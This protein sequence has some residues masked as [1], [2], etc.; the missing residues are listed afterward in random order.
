[1]GI[2][3]PLPESAKWFSALTTHLPMVFYILDAEGT[4]IMSEGL[5]LRKLGLKPG[6]VVGLSVFEVYK[7]YPDIV[8]CIRKALCGEY[9]VFDHAVG[10]FHVENH[11][12]P[13]FDETGKL[14]GLICAA[15][16]IDKR[17]Q[18]E[19]SLDRERTLT[20][21]I[22]NSVPGILYLYDAE[23]HL[24]YW[25]KSHEELTG[26]S[27]EELGRMTLPDWYRGDEAELA[28]IMEKVRIA[29]GG[30][31]T[32]ADANLLLKSGERLPMHLTA[33][34]LNID[35]KPHIT[36]I[37]IDNSE[38]K[39]AQ[40]R[41]L[42]MNRNL[43]AI[44][45]ERTRELT[46]AVQELKTTNEKM[47]SMQRFMIQS[48]KMAA[49]GNLVAGV[50]HEINTPIGI[51]V[52]GTSHLLDKTQ[53]LRSKHAQDG[54]EPAELDAYLEYV[55][56]AADI[57]L[58]NLNRAGKL[59]K[60]FKQVSA[61]QTSEPLRMFGVREYVDEILT[62]LSPML[63]RSH[64]T[65]Q[66]AGA[67]GILIRGYPGGFAQ[68]LTN[69]VMNALTH[70]FCPEDSGIISIN[71]EDVD[72]YVL[73]TFSDNGKGIPAEVLPKIFDPFFTTNRGNGGTGLGL[74]VLY[75]IVTQSFR[76]SLDCESTPGSGTTFH[77]RL[78]KGD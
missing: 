49:L 58:K 34:G 5:G 62:S 16:D 74:S 17:I 70:A 63:K 78:S 29:M 54:L 28:K 67:P 44:V 60:S 12:V 9:V 76:G 77:I 31:V 19:K 24:V 51:G 15:I 64:A 46:E 43:E 71:I 48:E 75:N 57:V 56:K 25:N 40:T 14:T 42:E 20:Q 61:D 1:M 45:E 38:L 30:Q 53:G 26:Y 69:L 8:S 72:T 36:G 59:V 33:V 35:G 73:L 13:E 66:L 65:V 37:G 2:K 7:D 32:S 6:Q 50:A 23:G 3:P 4:F 47:A 18:T 68:I 21:A 11:L 39:Q 22:M 27:A 52:T 10:D 41:L 55:E